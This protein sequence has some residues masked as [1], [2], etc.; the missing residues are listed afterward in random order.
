MSF[1]C[2]NV[3]QR[4]TDYIFLFAVIMEQ[5]KLIFF[6]ECTYGNWVWILSNSR[7][8]Y[9]MFQLVCMNWSSV[10]W[11][12]SKARHINS[13]GILN[14]AA[15]QRHHATSSIS[16]LISFNFFSPRKYLLH[17]LVRYMMDVMWKTED[18][19]FYIEDS[20]LSFIFPLYRYWFDKVYI[21]YPR[22]KYYL[23]WERFEIVSNNHA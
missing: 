11:K 1:Q 15:L 21:N 16:K 18:H 13:L 22:L 19:Q 7:Y 20:R 6:V 2:D 9:P 10:I 3:G 14:V 17:D 4:V 5:R 12:M 8:T 23:S